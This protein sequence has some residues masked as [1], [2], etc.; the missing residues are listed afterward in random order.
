[1]TTPA[2]A[3]PP[4]LR[5]V[6]G[7]W[8]L[9]LYGIILIQPTAPMPL[10]GIV[11]VT[12][13]GHVVTTILIGMFAMMLT[14]ISYGRMARAYPSAGSAYTYV[15]RELH[16]HAGF[17]TGWS[18]AMDYLINPIIC[19]IWCSKAAM[20]ILPLPY[21]VWA[22]FFAVLF[23]GLNLRG[24]KATARTNQA[25]TIGMGIVIVAFFVVAV[26]YIMGLQGFGGLFSTKPFYDPETFSYS[27]VSTG[28]SIAVLTYIGF[29]GISTLSEEVSNPRR[30]VM[31]ATV[32]TCVVTGILGGLQVYMGQ[33]IWP[34]Y[35]TFPD[36]DT[37]FVSAAGRAGGVVMF[38]VI[39]FTLLVATI[40][41]GSGAQLGGARLLYAMGRDDVIPRRFFGHLDPKR[42]TPSYNIILAGAIALIG[43]LAMTYQ[44]GAELLNFGAFIAFMG[45]NLAALT[46]YFIRANS[47]SFRDALVY[48]VPPALGFLVCLYIWWSLRTPAKIAGAAWL[49]FGVIYAAWKSNFF[50]KELALP[51]APAE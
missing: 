47:R 49:L 6:L 11:S 22:V 10:F 17:I 25:L 33:L 26:R 37:G 36:P 46:H 38:Q 13:R 32:L 31:L 51:E 15:G 20:N 34:D 23:T 8:D 18:M 9:V 39:N 44:L 27:L 42:H 29:D 41:S 50:Q 30:N 28:A 16:P 48:F 40:G 24:I 12:A 45:V 5:R 1:M 14:A 21:V 4:R 43:A 3:E 35:N 19:T 7:L 2:T